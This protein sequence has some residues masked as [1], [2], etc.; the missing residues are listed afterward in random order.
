[1]IPHILLNLIVIFSIMI[2]IDSHCPAEVKAVFKVMSSDDGVYDCALN[3]ADVVNNCNKSYIMQLLERQ[4]ETFVLFSRFGRVGQTGQTSTEVF[5]DK[6][7]AIAEFQRTFKEKS[8]VNWSDR[9]VDSDI[10]KGKYQFILKKSHDSTQQDP[11]DVIISNSVQTFIEM[12]YNPDLY[13]GAC[14][15]FGIDSRKLPLGSLALAQIQRASKIL[16]Q[17]N[18]AIANR[19]QETIEELSSLFYTTIPSAHSKLKLLSTKEDLEE[20]GDLLDLL[21]NMCYMSKSMDKSI[22]DKYLKLETKLEHVTD[23]KVLDL[24]SRY[25]KTNVGQTH[26]CRLELVNVYQVDKPKE[27]QAYRKWDSLHNKQLLWHGTRM[28]NAVGILSTGLL[29]N[30]VGVLTTGKM[31]GNGIYFANSSSKSAGYLGLSGN[32]IGIMFLC[33][34]ALGNMYERL[35]S[36]NVTKL[37]SGKHSTK[38][39]GCWQPDPDTHVEMDDVTIPIGKLTQFSTAGKALHYDEFIVYDNSQVKMRYVVVVQV[40]H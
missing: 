6:E 16:E 25:M 28:A 21:K 3:I 7:L 37:P 17:L 4:G 1:M 10:K 2:E 39:L 18:T 14:K 34:V 9:Y 5:V 22:I 19:E 40:Y 8:G 38:G 15:S 24:I 29:T 20:K 13:G 26:S 30:P 35:Q 31:F 32:G 12:I 36:E 27:A 23:I 11:T 33:E